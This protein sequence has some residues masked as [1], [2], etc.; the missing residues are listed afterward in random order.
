MAAGAGKAS[1]LLVLRG[2]RGGVIAHAPIGNPDDHHGDEQ[3]DEQFEGMEPPT[4][5]CGDEADQ[6]FERSHSGIRG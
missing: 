2:E 1:S 5:P 4:V 6:L 3:G